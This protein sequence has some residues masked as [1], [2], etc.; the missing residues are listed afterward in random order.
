RF[1][2]TGLRPIPLRATNLLEP[3]RTPSGDRKLRARAARGHPPG[4]ETAAEATAFP[5]LQSSQ[6][7]CR[8]ATAGWGDS[9]VW[10]AVP[11]APAPW[12]LC[13]QATPW[14]EARAVLPAARLCLAR[15]SWH[16]SR[17]GVPLLRLRL[18]P[19]RPS[20]RAAIAPGGR[21]SRAAGT[22]PLRSPAPAT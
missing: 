12:P 1:Q 13:T 16:L 7:R 6:R 11:P 20:T 4:G 5:G 21:P 10:S 2:A 19:V 18:E 8:K 3:Y 22:S 17:L 14:R 15:R 9:R